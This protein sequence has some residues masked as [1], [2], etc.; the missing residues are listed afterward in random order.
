M[1]DAS[2]AGDA[3]ASLAVRMFVHRARQ[4]IGAMAVTLGGIDALVFTGGIGEHSPEIRAAIA[5][6]LGCLGL[7]LDEKANASAQPDA[8]VSTLLSPAQILVF[9]ARED[10]TMAR[11]AAACLRAKRVQMSSSN[12]S[13]E[14]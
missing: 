5:E 6:G 11:A 1:L 4:S 9:T 13:A 10:L 7:V 8:V 2:N 3:R 12:S 14:C